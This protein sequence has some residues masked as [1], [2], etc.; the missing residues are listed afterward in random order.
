MSG[1]KVVLFLVLAVLLIFYV[2]GILQIQPTFDDFT[3]LSA[4]NR[5]HDWLKYFLPWGTTWRPVDALIGYINGININ[6]FPTLNH[7]IVIAAHFTSAW[8]IFKLARRLDI[9]VKGAWLAVLFF[10]ISPAML[11]TVLSVDATNQTLC[12]TFGLASTYTYLSHDGWKKYTIWILFIFLSAWSKDN[13]I[14]YICVG[15]VLCW[16]E[17]KF[18]NKQF[19]KQFVLALLVACVYGIIRLLLPVTDIGETGHVALMTNIVY[20]IQR[21]FV[22]IGYTWVATDYLSLLYSPERNIPIAVLTLLLSLPIMLIAFFGNRTIWRKKET[23][24]IVAV[25]FISA[26]P[27]LLIEMSLMNIYGS[28]GMSALLFGYLVDGYLNKTENYKLVKGALILY[29]I[30]AL[31]VDV[32]HWYKAWQTSIPSKTIAEKIVSKSHYK[33]DKAYIITIEDAK[34]KY[35][36]ICVPV[37]DVTGWGLDVYRETDYAW[38]KQLRDT[39]IANTPDAPQKA[40]RMA[41]NALKNYDAVWIVFDTNNVSVIERK[42]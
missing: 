27:N 18:S 14:A 30:S 42:K 3:T 4:P 20:K 11:G 33:A 36:S 1:K 7:L 26:S 35:S 39:M 25:I 41:E 24:A 9:D 8:L 19:G 21:F 31:I 16:G 17:G 15:P 32:H 38:P 22:W 40:V 10:I 37:Q 13:G 2:L 29:I 28:L 5:D 12:Q 23:W 34:P 6:L